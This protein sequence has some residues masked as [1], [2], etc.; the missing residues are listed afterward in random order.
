VTYTRL[1]IP[2]SRATCQP[3]IAYYRPETAGR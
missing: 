2:Q 3:I 1:C